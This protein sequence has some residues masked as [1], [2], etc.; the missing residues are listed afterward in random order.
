[1][2]GSGGDVNPR[3]LR[4]LIYAR[5]NYDRNLLIELKARKFR[6]FFIY[7]HVSRNKGNLFFLLVI[8]G[9]ISILIDVTL[10]K[11]REHCVFSCGTSTKVG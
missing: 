5:I 1:M 8:L 10:T 2:P 11:Q 4:P 3:D 6:M 7:L 9:A